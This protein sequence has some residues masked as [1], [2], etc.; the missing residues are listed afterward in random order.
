MDENLLIDQEQH[1]DVTKGGE[2]CISF[3]LMRSSK[4]LKVSVRTHPRVEE[5]FREISGEEVADVK[6]SARHWKGLTPETPLM[7]YIVGEKVAI[8]DKSYNLNR[9]G[10][11]LIDE[12][13]EKKFDRDGRHIGYMNSRINISFLRLTG[14]SDGNGVTFY[15][16]G[17][18]SK[19]AV[20]KL[21]EQIGGAL[22]SFYIDYIRPMNVSVQIS[23][24]SL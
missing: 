18:Y 4:G 23:T 17:V 10:H 19:E 16:G 5:F 14:I 3:G 20:T 15:V 13:N 12:G 7:A 24:Q 9:I 11:P 21:L 6:L 22:R 8:E 2:T 1:N